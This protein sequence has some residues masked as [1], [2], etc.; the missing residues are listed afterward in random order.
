MKK[1][2]FGDDCDDLRAI[3]YIEDSKGS[4]FSLQDQYF[5]ISQ[6][7]KVPSFCD[8]RKFSNKSQQDFDE[9][10]KDVEDFFPLPKEI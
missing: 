5:V 2:N 1:K 8:I 9:H 10:L 3:D 6:K 4:I 7:I